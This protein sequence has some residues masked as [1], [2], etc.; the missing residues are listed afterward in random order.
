MTRTW[1]RRIFGDRSGVA[2]SAPWRALCLSLSVVTLSVGAACEDAPADQGRA[3]G[4]AT[5]SGGKAPNLTTGQGEVSL[6]AIVDDGSYVADGAEIPARV[7]VVRRFLRQKHTNYVRDPV[8]IANTND[9]LVSAR[10][11]AMPGLWR[12]SLDNLEPGV[13][14]VSRPLFDPKTPMSSKNRS[15]WYIGTPRVFPDGTH[16]IFDGS[17]HSSNEKFGNVLGLASLEN[18]VVEPVEVQGT[19]YA[20]TPDVHPDGKTIVFSTCTELRSGTL[21]G[22][23]A[24]KLESRVLLEIPVQKGGKAGHLVCTIHRPRY[25]RDGKKIVFEGIGQFMADEIQKEY[26]VPPAVNPGDYVIEPWIM[27]A[28]GTGLRRLLTDDAYRQ[29]AGRVQT[30]GSKE[31]DFSPDGQSIIFSHGGGIAVA[32]VEGR[33]ARMVLAGAGP[34]AGKIQLLESDPVYSPDGKRVVAASAVLTGEERTR[35]APP[36]IAVVDLR[37][38][39]AMEDGK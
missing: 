21:H 33:T 17:R 35:L 32:D 26:A 29:I 20:R 7:G 38:L 37:V 18:G 6:P 10:I 5:A 4:S 25:S 27:N 12:L 31:P 23:G 11:G 36:G 9:V 13:V 24:Q 34:G 39:D 19:P 8:F 30:G 2:P 3:G 1:N 15:N 22:R 28:D 14:V 16:V